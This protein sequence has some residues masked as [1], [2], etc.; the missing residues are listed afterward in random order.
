MLVS[1]PSF[2]FAR[3][4]KSRS[5]RASSTAMTK[6]DADCLRLLPNRR[7]GPFHRLRDLHHR[8]PC[9]RMGFELSQILFGPRIADRSL[10]FRHGF[11][12]SLIL[13]DFAIVAARVEPIRLSSST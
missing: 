1:D 8:C 7:L 6:T 3:R 13:I 11:H 9:F 10:L 12:T 5:R 2:A 4:Q